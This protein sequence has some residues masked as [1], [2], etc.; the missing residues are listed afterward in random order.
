[1]WPK[2]TWCCRHKTCWKLSTSSKEIHVEPLPWIFC[3][4]RHPAVMPPPSNVQHIQMCLWFAATLNAP[5]ISNL[6]FVSF[7]KKQKTKAEAFLG[8]SLWSVPASSSL[9]TI[10]FC[11]S[12]VGF[13][14]K[15]HSVLKSANTVQRGKRGLSKRLKERRQRKKWKD[16]ACE[17]RKYLKA[18]EKQT[19][20]RREDKHKWL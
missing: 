13:W 15:A 12:T 8:F 14:S 16:L 4:S 6:K 2:I 17:R 20:H 11:G 9:Q 5:Q 19:S 10:L 3:C 1:M 18:S 7:G